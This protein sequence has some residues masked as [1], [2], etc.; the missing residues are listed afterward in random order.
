[1]FIKL[2]LGEDAVVVVVG[3]ETTIVRLSSVLDKV[4]A[5]IVELVVINGDVVVVFVAVTD[6]VDVTASE[7]AVSAVVSDIVEQG[8]VVA[9]VLTSKKNK[10]KN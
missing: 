10:N 4:P 7:T 9:L 2:L 5:A 6:A 1:M 3:V 8:F